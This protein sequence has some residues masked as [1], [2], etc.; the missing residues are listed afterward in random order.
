MIFYVLCFTKTEFIFVIF[1]L[2]CVEW[3]R[4]GEMKSCLQREYYVEVT[5]RKQS[6][7]ECV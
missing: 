6:L 1:Y 2:G 3:L 7:H 4:F 5:Q